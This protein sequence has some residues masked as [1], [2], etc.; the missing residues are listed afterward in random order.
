MVRRLSRAPGAIGF[1]VY[2]DLLENIAEPEPE[3]DVDV[4]LLC[5]GDDKALEAMQRAR[6]LRDAGKTVRVQRETGKI[7]G[8]ETIQ[9]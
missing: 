8:R 3:Y 5:P 7:R 6:A 4:L 9:L 2:L 1:A